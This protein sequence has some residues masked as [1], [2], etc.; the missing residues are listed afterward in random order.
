MP[1]I[2]PV[3]LED[4][5]EFIDRNASDVREG[6]Y[7]VKIRAE[8]LPVMPPEAVRFLLEHCV[9]TRKVVGRVLKGKGAGAAILERLGRDGNQEVRQCVAANPNAPEAVLLALGDDYFEEVRL[10]LARN[11]AL[12]EAL[13]NQMSLDKS[14]HIRVAVARNPQ[15][16]LAVMNRLA[17]DRSRMVADAVV[18]LAGETKSPGTLQLLAKCGRAEVRA[19]VCGN[20]WLGLPMVDLLCR[21]EDHRVREA[22]RKRLLEVARA[23]GTAPELLRQFAVLDSR[24]IREAVA[25]NP[26]APADLLE[27]FINEGEERVR[28]AVAGNP[29]LPEALMMLLVSDGRAGVREVLARRTDL[30]WPACELL[31]GDETPEI[32]E[33]LADNPAERE[34]RKAAGLCLDCG[35]KLTGMGRTISTQCFACMGKRLL[36]R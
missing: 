24:D 27:R 12:P 32:Q 30:C 25:G 2:D 7:D 21:D 4:C 20:R 6:T 33:A 36:N 18:E 5:L 14:P 3:S 22:A 34:R 9:S 17:N 31:N 26:S 29:S 28:M 8:W 19:A 11:P 13:L 15:T 16:S 35:R 10:T 1:V 23:P